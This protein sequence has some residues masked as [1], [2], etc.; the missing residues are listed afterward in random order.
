MKNFSMPEQV[1]PTLEIE[2][3][4][5]NPNLEKDPPALWHPGGDHEGCGRYNVLIA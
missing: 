2:A 1:S 4:F 3:A 5:G